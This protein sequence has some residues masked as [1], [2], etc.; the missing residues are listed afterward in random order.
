[1]KVCNRCAV[2]K[3]LDAF[4]KKKGS[5]DGLFWWCRDCHKAYVKA[6]YHDLARDENYRSAE[7]ARIRAYHQANPEKVKGWNARY[8]AANRPRL[9]AKSKAY[10]LSRERRTPQWLT[11]EDFWVLEEAYA[12]AALRTK[13][14]GFR[15]D[16][17]HIIPLHGAL[18]SGLHVPQNVQVIPAS[19]NQSKS[20]RYVVA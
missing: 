12:L 16:V 18:V 17:D 9:N 8:L 19:L 4:Y 1:M 11:A 3:P 15:W 10:V 2:S 20:N 13:L 7:R 5:R 6:K 14:F